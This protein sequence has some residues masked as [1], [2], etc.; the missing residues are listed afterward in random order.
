MDFRLPILVL[1]FVGILESHLR[2]KIM[3]TGHGWANEESD[4]Y[5]KVRVRR[6]EDFHF[7]N[8]DLELESSEDLKPLIKELEKDDQAMSMNLH[9]FEQGAPFTSVTFEIGNYDISQSFDDEKDLIGGLDI[10]IAEFCRIIENLSNESR[11]IWDTCHRKEFDVGFQS[12]NTKKS[13]HTLVQ[14]KTIKRC[15]K[16][17]AT[18][19]ITV[20]LQINHVVRL[21]V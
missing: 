1:L 21:F 12:G 2:D 13:F 17:R 5:I 14:A 18:I 8:V 3:L 19:G 4:E 11:K 9:L 7:I 16:I 15:A 10:H 6:K 20:Y